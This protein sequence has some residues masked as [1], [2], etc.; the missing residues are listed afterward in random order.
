MQQQQ[1]PG[2]VRNYSA[3]GCVPRRSFNRRASSVGLPM[4]L[5][6]ATANVSTVHPH[7][8]K[9]SSGLQGCDVTSRMLEL[10]EKFFRAGIMIACIQEGRLPC[11]GE[12]NAINFKMYHAGASKC[13]AG[14][15]QIWIAHCLV[16]YVT[17]VT[18]RSPW[19]MRVTLR[20]RSACFHVVSAHAPFEKAALSRRN[21]F[22]D[23]LIAELSSIPRTE[24]PFILL[25]IDANAHVGSIACAAFGS[26]GVQCENENGA[27]L[28]LLL[29]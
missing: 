6:L 27:A 16:K 17:G 12:S 7:E 8:L 26:Y 9:R 20:F 2:T 19:I 29:S 18:V 21:V 4:D 24:S 14:G 25:G 15:V 10:D 13:G 3:R 22:W 1:L 28:R 5:G 11:D 23:Q